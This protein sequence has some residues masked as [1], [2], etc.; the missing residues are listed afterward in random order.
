MKKEILSEV[1]RYREIMGLSLINEQWERKFLDLLG[2]DIEAML[3]K[4]P[5][6]Y[7]AIEKSL[8]DDIESVATKRGLDVADLFKKLESNDLKSLGK[9]AINDIQDVLLK[10][11]NFREDALE[12]F[13]ENNAS[14]KAVYNQIS[15]LG[16]KLKSAVDKMDKKTAQTLKNKIEDMIYSEKYGFSDEIKKIL[17]R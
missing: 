11:P 13:I 17:D 14:L 10:N 3:K 12:A 2:I 15:N 8:F 4:L 1:N 9:S 16:T 5:G 7:G 6:D